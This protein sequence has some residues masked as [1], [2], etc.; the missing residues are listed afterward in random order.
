MLLEKIRIKFIAKKP[1]V[2][3]SIDFGKKNI[4]EL[5]KKLGFLLVFS[6]ISCSHLKLNRQGSVIFFHPDGMSLAHWDLGR[7]ITEGP[8]GL[9]AWDKLPHM[10][11]YKP[12]LKNNLT[13]S[14]NAGATIHAYGVKAGYRSF[15][16]DNGKAFKH[17]S[18]LK[19]A[20]GKGFNTGLVQSGVLIEPGTAVFASQSDSRKNF[21]EIT[22]QLINSE[23]SILLGGGEKYLLP[24]GVK[25][26]F[27]K[28]VRTDNKN[29]IQQVEK[30]GYLVIYTL[31][32][33]KNIPKSAKK[34]LGVFAYENTYNDKTEKVLKQ[35]K[36][37]P[38]DE[39][40]PTIAQMSKYALEFLS[41]T[42]KNFFLVVEEEGTDNF[43]NLNNAEA[44][45]EAIRRSLNAIE[46]FRKFL[47]TY[48]NTLL[49]VASDS[50][51]SSPA[52][53]DRLSS[54]KLFSLNKKIGNKSDV[55]APLDRQSN[56][57]PFVSQANKNG[58]AMP[59]AIAW[60]T[61]MDTGTGLV[62]KAEGFKANQVQGV[63]DNTDIYKI[64]RRTL[65][66]Y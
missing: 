39:Q 1:V 37:K 12:H 34:V 21:L 42:D 55:Q 48:K 62:V 30:R 36:L 53:I 7:I 6:L 26:R 54:K 28:G 3:A 20:Q 45:F 8:D 40:A 66:A 33:L 18:I 24:K 23:V 31:E 47:K 19:L 46:I 14:S 11:V 51:A 2:K 29:L 56:G 44:L 27:G 32:E 52:L 43:S 10:A 41:R 5:P 61:R 35:N 60:P 16:K 22:E 13:A 64:I 59:F 63:L 15:G 9:S 4:L 25:G 65:F 49:I 17:P 38:Y 50:N 57:L 58:I